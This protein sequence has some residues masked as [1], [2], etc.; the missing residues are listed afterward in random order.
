M[1]VYREGNPFTYL[2]SCNVPMQFTLNWHGNGPGSQI[3]YRVSQNSLRE[4]VFRDLE[5]DFVGEEP[6]QMGS[7]L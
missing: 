1:S 3:T 7:A 2:N 4:L 5:G 6:A